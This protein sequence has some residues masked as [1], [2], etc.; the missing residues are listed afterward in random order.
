M[1][2][3]L[4]LLVSLADAFRSSMVFK[5]LLQAEA[6]DVCQI[7][8]VSDNLVPAVARMRTSDIGL[9]PRR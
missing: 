3:Q 8:S 4:D 5:Q 6:I 1:T 7:D 9:P 2:S